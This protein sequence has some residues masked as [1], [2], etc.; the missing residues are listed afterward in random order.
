MEV[1]LFI[2]LTILLLFSYL[3]FAPFFI[4]ANS[5]DG[6]LRVRFHRIFSIRLL[7]AKDSLYLSF[8]LA[9]WQWKTNLLAGNPNKKK[10]VGVKALKKGSV[11]ITFQKAKAVAASFKLNKLYLSISFDDMSMNG[12]TYPWFRILNTF[13]KG[14]IQ[15]NFRNENEIIL[16]IENSIF[17][18]IM[19]YFKT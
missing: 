12:I 5:R 15:I 3:I 7:L 4:E 8:N 10:E 14:H 16:E 18:I 6:L 9:G 11:G 1:L 17:R 19:A 2:L 13:T